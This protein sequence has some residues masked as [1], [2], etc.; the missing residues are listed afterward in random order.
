MQRLK[1]QRYLQLAKD[2]DLLLGERRQLERTLAEEK[3][4]VRKWQARAEAIRKEREYT[5]LMSEIGSQKRLI[6]DLEDKS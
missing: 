4:K 2:Y 6:N 3:D 1:N 5:A